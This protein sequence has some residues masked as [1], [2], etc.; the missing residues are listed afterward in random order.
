MHRHLKNTVFHLF[1]APLVVLCWSAILGGTF[2]AE[3]KVLE[4]PWLDATTPVEARVE[5]LLAE[6]TLAEKVGQLGQA[7]GIGGKP[8]GTVQELVADECALRTR[9]EGTTGS[10]LNEV[11]L[12]TVN[13]FQRLAVEESR[14]GIPLIIGRDVIHGYRTIFPIPLGQAATWSPELVEAACHVAAREARSAGIHWTFA[15]MMDIAA[16]RGGAASRKDL[17]KTLSWRVHSQLPRCGGIRGKISRRMIASRLVRSTLPDT[18]RRKGAAITTP[19]RFRPRRCG[20]YTC[21]RF[22]RPSMPGSPP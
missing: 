15:P 16:I 13:E 5:A 20:M 14:L 10:I 3:T 19:C 9:A 1:L 8:T 12:P 6:M 11:H 2:A 21:R 22:V 17:V 7:N 4:R 18:G